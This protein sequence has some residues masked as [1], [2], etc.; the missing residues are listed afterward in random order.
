LLLAE[1]HALAR[2]AFPG[3][4]T[5]IYR[6]PKDKAAEI[7]VDTVRGMSEQLVNVKEVVFVCFDTENLSLYTRLLL[8]PA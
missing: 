7:A 4:S 6:F 8:S 5:G 1:R 3:I 2:I